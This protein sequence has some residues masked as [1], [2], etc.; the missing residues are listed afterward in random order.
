VAFVGTDPALV[1]PTLLAV[2]TDSTSSEVAPLL[3]ACAVAAS[4][5]H[6]S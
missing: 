1:M 2:R 3:H 6:G 4:S 5:D